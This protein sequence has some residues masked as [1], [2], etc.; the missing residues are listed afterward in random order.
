[1]PCCPVVL[2]SL[3]SWNNEHLQSFEATW[4]L[5]SVL[6]GFGTSVTKKK[7]ENPSLKTKDT[8]INK[9]WMTFQYDDGISADLRSAWKKTRW[10]LNPRP[11]FFSSPL[12][13][14]SAVGTLVGIII[15]S[16]LTSSL[17]LITGPMTDCNTTGGTT[18]D[19]WHQWLYQAP[20]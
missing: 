16:R 19:H 12:E 13:G 9:I 8:T 6:D 4:K 10:S 15:T 3:P 18:V 17:S 7:N 11:A 1:M 20:A 5:C 2:M 14:L